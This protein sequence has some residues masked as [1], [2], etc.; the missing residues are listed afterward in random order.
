MSVSLKRENFGNKAGVMTRKSI[1]IR[2]VLKS[3]MVKSVALVIEVCGIR[4]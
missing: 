2:C 4:N 1:E 3:Q